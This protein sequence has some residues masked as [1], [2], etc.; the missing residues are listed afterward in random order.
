MKTVQL[1]TMSRERISKLAV[2]ASNITLHTPDVLT[3]YKVRVPYEG[4]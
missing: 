1:L 4:L 2:V 3:V